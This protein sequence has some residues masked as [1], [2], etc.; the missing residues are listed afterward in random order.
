MADKLLKNKY[1]NYVLGGEMVKGGWGALLGN[2]RIRRHGCAVP[3]KGQYPPFRRIE[4]GLRRRSVDGLLREREKEV[5]LRSQPFRD[6]NES[7]RTSVQKRSR[8]RNRRRRG[9]L[10]RVFE[11][12]DADGYAVALRDNDS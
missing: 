10:H 7:Y 1:G 11:D 2:D 9:A 12:N 5:V 8:I 6:R 4:T 3:R